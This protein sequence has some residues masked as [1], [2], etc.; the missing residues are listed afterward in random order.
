MFS[1]AFSLALLN[2]TAGA[3]VCFSGVLMFFSGMLMFFSGMFVFLLVRREVTS[4]F[5]PRRHGV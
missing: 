3:G 1:L 2:V 5:Y 4:T